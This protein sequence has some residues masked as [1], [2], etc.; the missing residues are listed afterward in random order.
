ME[1][2]VSA[3]HINPLYLLGLAWQAAHI[4]TY[5][6]LHLTYD[7]NGKPVMKTPAFFFM[8]SPQVATGIGM[9]FIGLTLLLSILLPILAP[10]SP[11]Y[12]VLVLAAGIY[13]L[14]S[15]LRF[16][17]DSLSRERG[18]KA[19]ASLSIFRLTISVAIL[20]DIFIYY[21]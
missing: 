5:Y 12:L 9:G 17:K 14:A 10:L 2:D 4:M 21:H 7:V 13:A 19:F 8:P 11:L 3:V 20:L 16:F 1:Y 6:P 15:G 18:L